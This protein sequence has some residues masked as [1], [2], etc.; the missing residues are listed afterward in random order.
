MGNKEGKSTESTELTPKRMKHDSIYLKIYC[1][2]LSILDI[3]LLKA[4]TNYSEQEIRDWYERFI[5]DCPNGKLSKKQ[6]TRLYKQFYEDG[7]ADK[8]CKDAFDRFDVDGNGSIDFEE[9][10]LA[11]S[12]SSQAN[13]E[14]RLSAAFDICDMSNDGQIDQRELTN[15]ITT[16]YDL[17]GETDRKGEKDPKRR[18]ME[19]MRSLDINGDRKLNKEEF[20][21]G[22]KND[23]HICKLLA[24]NA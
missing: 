9:F 2:T 21:I 10:L 11:L 5:D 12:V 6:F 1:F 3:A 14:D 15:W 18:A 4:N 23:S 13:L 20:I 7:E 17:V 8:I 19:I 16:I 22:C 24:L